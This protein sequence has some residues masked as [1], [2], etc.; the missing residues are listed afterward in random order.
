M[1]LKIR[2]AILLFRLR[3]VRPVCAALVDVCGICDIACDHMVAAREQPRVARMVCAAGDG[4][5]TTP[6]VSSFVLSFVSQPSTHQK[7]FVSVIID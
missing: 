2:L 7:S 4:L 6:S 5:E 3:Q 1:P